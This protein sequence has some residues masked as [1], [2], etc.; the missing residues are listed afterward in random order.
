MSVHL[1]HE[2]LLPPVNCPL[3][4][5]VDEELLSA[6]RE[7]HV[8]ARGRDMVYILEDGKKLTGQFKWTYP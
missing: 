8:I 3:L 4:I 6:F 1:N 7:S 5:E 2:T